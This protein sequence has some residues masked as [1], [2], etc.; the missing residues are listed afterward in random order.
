[1]SGTDGDTVS[2]LAVGDCVIDA[3]QAGNANYL[4]AN[5]V[6]QTIIVV[7]RKANQSITF[8]A[9]AKETLAQS[10]VTVSA[11][12]SSGLTVSFITTTPGVCTS[13]GTNG[14]TITLVG[15]GAC[16]VQANQAGNATY[17]PA[18]AVTRSFTV[19][20]PK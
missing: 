7:A 20:K 19:T 1:L 4:A 3:V 14:A 8:A 16:S 10:P 13:G 12:A 6:Q 5:Q 9:L 11:K 15:T 17:N 2:Y 18:S